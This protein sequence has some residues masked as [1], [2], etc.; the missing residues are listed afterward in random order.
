MTLRSPGGHNF[1]FIVELSARK[2]AA[3]TGVEASWVAVVAMLFNF[4][5]WYF[6]S[7]KV[8]EKGV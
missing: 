4:S 6:R 8:V 5:I 2:D 1:R 3:W 7:E